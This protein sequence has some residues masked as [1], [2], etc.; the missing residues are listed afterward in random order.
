[1]IRQYFVFNTPQYREYD[2]RDRPGVRRGRPRALVLRPAEPA[3]ADR[4]AP[5]RQ[6]HRHGREPAARARCPAPH[7]SRAATSSGYAGTPGE[8]AI[9]NAMLAGRTGRP[10][11]SFGALGSLMYGP[12]VRGPEV[13]LMS[14]N[15]TTTAAA[16]KLGI[17]TICSVLVTGLLAAIMGNIGFGGGKEYK[18]VFSTASMLQKG[19]D[20]RIAGVNVGE[21]REVEHYDRTQALV[22]FRIKDEIELTTAS[23]AEIRFLNL[24]GDRYLALEQG[25]STRRRGARGRRHHPDRP[26][27][28]R[29]G[30]DRPVQ[31]LPAAV[32]GAQP[33][34]GQRPEP[35][36]RP[37]APGRGRHRRRAG[38]EDRLADQHRWPT[39]TS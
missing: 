13:R 26:D 22:T 10:A 20:V 35:E 39:A 4:P 14:R 12:V 21:V 17:F 5:A 23:R 16:V 11:D 8:Q 19:D 32:P 9:I 6:R 34:A 29:A 38:A 2:Q 30:P 15:S 24:V 25:A 3:G 36:P 31:R 37:G 7:P 28:P 27:Q 18:A 33:P 1:M